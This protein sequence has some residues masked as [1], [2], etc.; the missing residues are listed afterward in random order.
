MLLILLL[1]SSPATYTAACME[2]I[3]LWAKTLLPTL[4]PFMVCASL[5]SKLGVDSLS[6]KLSPAMR[7]LKLPP[8]AALCI[9]LS[10]LSGY[11]IGSRTLL[12]LKNAGWIRP[13]DSTRVSVICSTSGPMFILGSVGL[14]MYKSFIAGILLL[15]SH[16]TAILIVGLAFLPFIRPITSY[17]S[18]VPIDGIAHKNAA[19][20]SDSIQSSV[21]TILYV[22]GFIAFF[23]VLTHAIE[24]TGILKIPEK[25]FTLLL[26]GNS[27]AAKGCLLGLLEATRGC[28]ILAQ[29]TT[30][31]SMACT[32]FLITFGG[33]SILAQQLTFLKPAGVN[34]KRF[35]GIKLL[36]S[37]CSFGICLCLCIAFL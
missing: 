26:Q 4:F 19:S 27:S 5:L 6:D 36:Q 12:D 13:Q 35:I 2:G 21:I 1:L 22:G 31:L 16:L 14:T 8:A 23:C 24:N 34:V 32:A 29:E 25:F 17:K 37:S 3:T 20:L 10:V 7:R 18:S 28:A 9:L 11:P 15:I 30:P 33:A